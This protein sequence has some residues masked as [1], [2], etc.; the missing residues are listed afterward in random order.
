MNSTIILVGI[1]A[2]LLIMSLCI[3]LFA[4]KNDEVLIIL[5]MIMFFCVICSFI[6]C[7]NINTETKQNKTSQQ[8]TTIQ[9]ENQDNSEVVN[10]Y[11]L[12]EMDNGKYYTLD[13]ATNT[14]T[15]LFK[16]GNVVKE[17]SFDQTIT[18][19]IMGQTSFPKLETHSVNT[20]Y[21][22]V[23]IYIPY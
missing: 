14:I 8:L 20:K 3:G 19:I 22:K 15:V 12:T 7:C 21:T 17:E 11:E 16:D 5:M 9:Q 2:V 4:G 6:V 10:T 1:F 23:M 18:K 13:T